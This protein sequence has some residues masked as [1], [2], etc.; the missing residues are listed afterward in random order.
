MTCLEIYQHLFA[1]DAFAGNPCYPDLQPN[2]F[3][4][5]VI[6]NEFANQ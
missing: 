5:A 1:K 3:G 4:M 6:F 2:S